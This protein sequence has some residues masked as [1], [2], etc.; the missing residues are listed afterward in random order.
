MSP[1][2]LWPDFLWTLVLIPLFLLAYRRALNRRPRAAISFPDAG[3]LASAARSGNPFRRHLAAGLFIVAVAA[4]LI[5]VARPVA[6]L[7]VPA[8]RSAI[9][10]AIDVSGS[11]RSQDIL[12]SRLA[13]AQEAAKTF[14]RTVP[15]LVRVGLVSFG[16]TATLLVPPGTDRQRLIEAIDGFY[17]IRRTAIG[18]GLIEAVA[19][20]PGRAKPAADG[21]LQPA[22][23]GGWP[24]GVVILLSDGRSNTG[25]DPLVAASLARTQGVIVYTIGVGQ[26]AP[27][28][29]WTI[30]GTLDDEELR[31]IAREAGGEYFHASSAEGLKNVYRH[32]ARAVGWERRPEEITA[33]VGIIGAIALVASLI[34]SRLFTHPVGA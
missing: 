23:P 33:I 29:A 22:P 21:S 11:M 25:I 34:T 20:L 14:I 13:A 7:P 5:A 19:A 31:S 12:P 17:F 32:L 4:I 2:F 3:L 10:L 9:I 1:L 27:S 15:P 18:E 6:P 30:G 24:P 16:G 26:T 8:D 28:S